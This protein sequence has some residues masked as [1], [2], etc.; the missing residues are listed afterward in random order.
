MTLDLTGSQTASEFIQDQLDTDP[1]FRAEWERL[2]LA[3]AVAIAITR[4]R[5]DEKLSLRQMAE[6]LGTNHPQVVRLESGDH[7][8]DLRTLRLLAEKLG[9]SFMVSIQP[10]GSRTFAPTTAGEGRVFD[11]VEQANGIRVTVAAAPPQTRSSSIG[12]VRRR[13]TTLVETEKTR[14]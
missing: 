1:E 13:R 8:P 3:R 11:Q 9:M 4:Y 2:A 12:S 14:S 5:H 7:E 6:L 10:R